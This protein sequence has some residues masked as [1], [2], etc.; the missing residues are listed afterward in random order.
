MK[1][2]RV[3][4]IGR[5]IVEKYK[6][7]KYIVERYVVDVVSSIIAVL[8]GFGLGALLLYL[9]GYDPVL[10]YSALFHGAFGTMDS[11]LDT[12]TAMIPIIFAGLSAAVMFK[13]SLFF[14]GMEGQVYI[15]AIT[16]FLAG[17][18]ISAPPGVH[19][20][21]ALIAGGLGGVLWGLLPGYLRAYHG[22]NETVL[23]IMLNWVAIYLSDYVVEY[24][25]ID[26]QA[27]IA[28]T[29]NVNP[30]AMIPCISEDVS[31]NYMFF[32][33]IVS[34]FIVGVL[35]YKTTL[36]YEIR[37][38]GLNPVASRVAK[39]SVEKTYFKTFVISGFLAGLAGASMVLGVFG[40]LVYRFSPGYGWDGI[41]AAL[42]AR[43]NP[44][45][46]IPAS[47]LL[48][49]LRT[50]SIGMMLMTGVSN[51]MVLTIQGVV[52]IV[53]ALPEIY[54][55]IYRRIVLRRYKL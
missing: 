3:V 9:T 40:A 14:I 33:A 17:Y 19:A 44:F 43:N 12:L 18:L 28:R 32:V 35:I 51:E 24:A 52:L 5:D 39:I 38:V 48:A 11:V 15:G 37:C 26:P 21:I 22:V 7:Y 50:G 30:S 2:K 47:L 54:R 10:A 16:A 42:I 4:D 20:V 25:F 6:K 45:M 55:M 41:T 36:G 29:Y 53:A 13:A 23:A 49:T 8:A 1:M 46:I 34:C 27:T 31:L